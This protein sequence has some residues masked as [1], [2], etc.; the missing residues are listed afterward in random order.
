MALCNKV[1]YSNELNLI[2]SLGPHV[3]KLGVLNPWAT[4]MLNPSPAEPGN[5]LPLQTV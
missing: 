5:I 4:K 2:C 1:P 3:P